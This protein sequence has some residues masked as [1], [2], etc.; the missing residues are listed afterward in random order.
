MVKLTGSG[1]P[2]IGWLCLSDFQAVLG[3]GKLIDTWRGKQG[4]RLGWKM[5]EM[6]KVVS[7]SSFL[8]IGDWRWRVE[9][10][11]WCVDEDSWRF[12]MCN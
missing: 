2:M 9:S 1:L 5:L 3:S 12:M 10:G 7:L 8:R 6:S 4:P 11:I